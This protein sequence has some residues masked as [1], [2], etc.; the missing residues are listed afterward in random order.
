MSPVIETVKQV[1]ILKIVLT[2]HMPE[3]ARCNHQASQQHCILS[4]L[5]KAL[6]YHPRDGLFP[7]NC[8]WKV[9]EVVGTISQGNPDLGSDSPDGWSRL[10]SARYF[11]VEGRGL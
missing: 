10:E 3:C 2:F 6:V 7:Y 8:A 1:S 11:W 5:R 9:S 4:V